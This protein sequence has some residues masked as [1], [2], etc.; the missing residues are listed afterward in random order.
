[1]VLLLHPALPPRGLAARA[2]FRIVLPVRLAQGLT[3]RQ[4]FAKVSLLL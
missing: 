4:T 3:L 2:G 1:M